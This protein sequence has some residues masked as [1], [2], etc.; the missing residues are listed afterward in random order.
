MAAATVEGKI[1]NFDVLYSGSWFERK[2]DNSTDYT[3]YTIAYDQ[4]G[5][6]YTRF[7]DSNG[8]LSPTQDPTQY[9]QNHDKYTKMSHE[10]R[11]SSPQDNRFRYVVGAFY[12]RQTDNIRAEFRVDGLPVGYEVTGQP[13]I[14]YL[15]QQDRADRDY[16][17]FGEGTFDITDKLKISAGG[18]KFWV[19]NTLYGFFGFNSGSSGEGSCNPPAPAVVTGDRPCVNTDKKG[20]AKRRNS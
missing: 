13:D 14:L 20:G 18:R 11:L 2:V 16:A 1:G 19:N 17:L 15:S 4:F 9:N 3:N 7:V 10:I 5:S 6:G 12:Q 8:V